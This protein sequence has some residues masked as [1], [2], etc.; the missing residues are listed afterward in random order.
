MSAT[1]TQQYP[2]HNIYSS[3]AQSPRHRNFPSPFSAALNTLT[4]LGYILSLSFS[5]PSLLLLSPSLVVSLQHEPTD[6]HRT[7]SAVTQHQGHSSP[8]EAKPWPKGS[9]ENCRISAEVTSGPRQGPDSRRQ[10]GNYS[11]LTPGTPMKHH[12]DLAFFF[13]RHS[14]HGCYLVSKEKA[15]RSFTRSA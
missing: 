14:V 15:L 4:P 5:L 2:L 11:Q 1:I 3:L 10:E 7:S 8:V 6:P 13:L 12:Y 9:S